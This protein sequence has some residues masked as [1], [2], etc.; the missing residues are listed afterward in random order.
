[1]MLLFYSNVQFFV[2]KT[3]FASQTSSRLVQTCRNLLL[4]ISN[5]SQSVPQVKML[6]FYS[7]M[8]FLTAN[9]HFANFSTLSDNSSRLFVHRYFVLKQLFCNSVKHSPLNQTDNS[10]IPT[11]NLFLRSDLLFTRWNRGIVGL[12]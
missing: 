8:Q 9:L 7:N 12:N 2:S 10:S 4:F 11:R 1:M 6:S 5:F 3:L